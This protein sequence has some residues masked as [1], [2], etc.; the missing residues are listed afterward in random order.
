MH[1]LYR[2]VYNNLFYIIFK[3]LV[4]YTLRSTN[5]RRKLVKRKRS[6]LSPSGARSAS[7]RYIQRSSKSSGNAKNYGKSASVIKDRKSTERGG[8]REK[9]IREREVRG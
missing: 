9:G 3:N 2:N 6:L 4:A 8:E 5:S 7:M 1:I